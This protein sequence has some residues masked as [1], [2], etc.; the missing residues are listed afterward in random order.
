MTTTA[1]PQ[2]ASL[3]EHQDEIQRVRQAF[4]QT[5]GKEPDGVW[6]APG[7]VNLLGE[8]IDVVGGSCMPMP[9]PNR[10]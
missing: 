10:T 3:P 7:R 8:Y 9:L 5:Y 1:I 6:S 4:R 2:W